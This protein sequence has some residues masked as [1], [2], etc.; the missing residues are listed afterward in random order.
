MQLP[1]VKLRCFMLRREGTYSSILL[2]CLERSENRCFPCVWKWLK[3]LTARELKP[4]WDIRIVLYFYFGD[5]LINTSEL[6]T[7]GGGDFCIP[8][9]F[10][11]K[12]DQKSL[13]EEKAFGVAAW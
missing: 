10:M 11:N 6:H 1:G 2:I 3:E 5:Y 4:L 8:S 13:F 9:V 7:E 12:S